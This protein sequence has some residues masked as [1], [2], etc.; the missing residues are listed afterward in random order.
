MGSDLHN[1]ESQLRSIFGTWN[2]YRLRLW[3]E[4]RSFEAAGVEERIGIAQEILADPHRGDVIWAWGGFVMLLDEIQKKLGDPDPHVRQDA[5]IALAEFGSHARGAVPLLLERL[6]SN[7][8]PTHDR[9]LSA[10]VLPRI[11]V[12]AEQGIPILLTVLDETENETEADELRRWAAEAVES[13]TDSFRVLVP[14]AR[15]CLK[16]R[17]WK[18]RL[19]GLLM[20]ERLVQRERRLLPMLVPNVESLVS[21][22]VEEIRE[23]AGRVLEGFRAV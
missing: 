3:Q 6:R 4:H 10:W 18:C 11:G 17:Y 5:V 22:E 2:H 7:E 23:V 13:L 21:D 12:H 20:V 15:R 19:H 8:T 16:D 14:L 9:T 1:L